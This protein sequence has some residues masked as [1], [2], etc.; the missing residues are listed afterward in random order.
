MHL[1]I[2]F[3]VIHYCEKPIINT[4]VQ[5]KIGLKLWYVPMEDVLNAII[6]VHNQTGR[7]QTIDWLVIDFKTH[8]TF[9]YQTPKCGKHGWRLQ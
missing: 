1:E 2:S 6:N 7:L 5:T 9:R 4:D 3:S 8:V